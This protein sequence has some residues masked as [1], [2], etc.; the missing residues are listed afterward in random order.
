MYELNI[1]IDDII[2]ALCA[3]HK[4]ANKAAVNKAY[5]YA[6]EKHKGQVRKTGE[7]YIMHPLRVARAI[8]SWGFE[9]EVVAA[10]L[11]H[12]IVEDCH[13]P[14]SEIT[15]KFGSNIAGMVD[16]LTAVN[17]DLIKAQGL[18]KE[19]IDTMSDARLQKK[20]SEKALFIKV[21]DRLDN[22]RTIDG[23]KEEAKESQRPSIPVRFLFP[24]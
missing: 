6:Y 10:A 21:A 19:E 16:T 9:S 4:I 17:K 8:A 22:L 23:V 12:D 14:V 1:C 18:T 2:N 11:L 7:P 3:N 15:E 13:T 24:C 5:T 20:M